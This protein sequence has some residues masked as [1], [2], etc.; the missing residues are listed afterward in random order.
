[1]LEDET[2]LALARRMRG[3]VLAIDTAPGRHRA[4]SSP[5]M[6]RS[7]VVLPRTRRPEQRHQL[8]VVDLEIDAVER[9]EIAEALGDIDELRCSCRL[10]PFVS[11]ACDLSSAYQ[12]L[13]DE[14]HQRKQRQQRRHGERG[15]ELYSL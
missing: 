11:S 12:A 8:A 5:A 13:D 3:G 10:F 6:M 4:Y 9:D 2:D 14:R 7:S 1:M 15:R